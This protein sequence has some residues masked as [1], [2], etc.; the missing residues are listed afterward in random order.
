MDVSRR[1][2]KIIIIGSDFNTT[3]AQNTRADLLF[4]LVHAC[5]LI[6]GDDPILKPFHELWTYKHAVYG[7]RQIDFM[8]FSRNIAVNECHASNVIDLGSD[9]RSVLIKIHSLRKR[10]R[11]SK[12][13]PKRAWRSKDEFIAELDSKLD[14]FLDL[15]SE[16]L[17]MLLAHCAAAWS[18]PS[19]DVR[20]S[21]SDVL[22]ATMVDV[23]NFP[24]LS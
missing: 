7:K 8:L 20:L 16:S 2:F 12:P 5:D 22:V 21:T 24:K 19:N 11:W 1:G 4:E 18:K 6:I 9:H 13:K 14:Q 10:T 15:T 3:I 17:S 23:S